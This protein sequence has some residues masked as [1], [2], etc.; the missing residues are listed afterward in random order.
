LL[1]RI[2]QDIKGAWLQ[3]FFITWSASTSRSSEIELEKRSDGSAQFLQ[4]GFPDGLQLRAFLGFCFIS[5]RYC[6][7]VKTA[8]GQ[9]RR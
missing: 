3:N 4:A 2:D 1:G 8:G 5:F 6:R 7:L 9:A